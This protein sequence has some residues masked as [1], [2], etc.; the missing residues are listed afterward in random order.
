MEPFKNIYNKKSIELIAKSIKKV[1]V[2]LDDVRFVNDCLLNLKEKEMKERV[3]HISNVIEKY[4]DKDFKKNQIVLETLIE[5]LEG[6][7]LWPIS[8]YIENR[9]LNYFKESMSLLYLLTKKFTSEFAIRSFLEKYPTECYE[10]LM[11]WSHD[12][13]EHVRRLVSEGTRPNLPWAKK[14]GHINKQPSR[15]IDLLTTLFDDESLYVRKSVANHLNDISRLD[16]DA[17]FTFVENQNIDNKNKKW[18]VRHASRSLLKTADKK[19]LALH[20]YSYKAKV[21]I[22]ELKLSKSRVQVGDDFHINVTI[23]NKE[24]SDERVLLEYVIGFLKANGTLSKKVFRLKDFVLKAGQKQSLTKKVSMK[25]VST[26]RYYEGCH[27]LSIQINGKLSNEEK[28][29]LFF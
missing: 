7:I 27:N 24:K 5:D 13:C 18:I 20:G 14:V 1:N 2:E 3:V 8:F 10:L 26:R 21:K 17:F 11:K 29:N 12:P 23:E 28:F 6:F 25:T 9:G 22:C 4:L 19:A 15:H 16:R